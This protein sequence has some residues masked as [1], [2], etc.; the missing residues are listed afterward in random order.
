MRTKL[1]VKNRHAFLKNSI[2]SIYG[3]NYKKENAIIKN[4][5]LWIEERIQKM[6]NGAL[7]DFVNNI[8][9][10][11][12]EVEKFE[13][14]IEIFSKFLGYTNTDYKYNVTYLS[15]N[16]DDFIQVFQMLKKKDKKYKEIFRMLI[17]IGLNFELIA[18][19]V[20][21]I[22]SNLE[23]YYVGINKTLIKSKTIE[24]RIS[25]K[26]N[27][28]EYVFC[29]EYEDFENGKLPEIIREEV[30]KFIEIKEIRRLSDETS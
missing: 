12:I 1:A 28:E 18:D 10:E 30:E 22:N 6:K 9:E 8:L 29:K 19:Q 4:N 3:N 7:N 20:F 14:Y 2:I 25:F 26:A 15:Q 21:Y 17:N 5:G 23:Y 27:N 13:Q 16:I 11:N 24:I